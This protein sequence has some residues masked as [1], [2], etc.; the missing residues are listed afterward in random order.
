[1]SIYNG[2][3]FADSCRTDKDGHWEQYTYFQNNKTPDRNSITHT[4]ENEPS[5]FKSKHLF[6][7]E[8]INIQTSE[9]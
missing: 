7:S 9:L 5:G 3:W 1:M 2:N 8:Y 4:A 6:F